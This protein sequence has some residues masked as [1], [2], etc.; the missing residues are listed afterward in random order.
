VPRALK[1]SSLAALAAAG[2]LAGALAAGGR[3]EEPATTTTDTAAAVTTAAA[4]TTTVAETTTV[5]ETTTV[6]ETTTVE[7]TTTRILQVPASPT[8]TT[9][10][11]SGSGETPAWVWVLIAVLGIV[12]IATIVL[13]GRR[14]RGP[15]NDVS[16]EQQRFQ[17]DAAV[18]SWAAQGWAIA[19]QNV[20]SAVLH[21]GDE[22]MLV[23]VDRAGNVTTRPLPPA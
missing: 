18:G 14:T 22:S 19:S 4:A 13:L 3:A 1:L 2:L 15:T 10:S 9:A 16:V 6:T 21:R 23:S 8:T 5:P 20:D 17:L 12:L 11:S 7:H